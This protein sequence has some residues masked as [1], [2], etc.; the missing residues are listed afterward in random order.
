MAILL[1]LFSIPN[2]LFSAYPY[3]L[4]KILSIFHW[5]IFFPPFPVHSNIFIF[6]NCLKWMKDLIEIPC[7]YF[8]CVQI[9]ISKKRFWIVIFLFKLHFWFNYFLLPIN[10]FSFLKCL[11]RFLA[12]VESPDISNRF[13]SP[14]H[15]LFL[16]SLLNSSMS[17]IALCS[18]LETHSMQFQT[19][20]NNL[21]I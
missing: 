1:F 19:A 16:I 8:S 11:S 14:S 20:H 18:G 10:L 6:A 12:F 4:Q 2:H 5:N 15:F 21:T 7:R 13:W 9:K 17:L 3:V